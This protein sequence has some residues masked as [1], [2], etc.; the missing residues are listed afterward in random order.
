[1]TANVID[2]DEAGFETDVLRRSLEVPVVIDFWAEWCGPCHALSPILERAVNARDGDVILAKVD[3][4][5]NP[6]LAQAFQV[7]GIPAVKVISQG[8]LVGEFTG[9]QPP[10]FVEQFLDKVA[11]RRPRP[12]PEA[13]VPSDPAEA[14]TAWRAT[15]EE[16]PADLSARLGLAGLALDAGELDEADELLRPVATETG[17][18]TMLGRVKLAREAADPGSPYAEAAASASRGAPE[19]ALA[20][21][22]EA[23]R[24]TSGEERDRPRGLMLAIFRLLGDDDPRTQAYRR[25][26]MSVL[27]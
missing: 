21:L 18:E 8:R 7:Q 26:L 10:P 3:V 16:N 24:V 11:P 20:A 5:A 25:R 19:P 27:Y 4:D 9:A 14:A 15:L 12:E 1:M 2:V 6:R 17:A 13:V 22:L 23:V